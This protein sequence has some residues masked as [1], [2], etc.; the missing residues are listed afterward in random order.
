MTL[1][2]L[3]MR[4]NTVLCAI[5][6]LGFVACGGGSVDAMPTELETSIPSPPTVITSTTSPT[7]AITSTSMPIP[8]QSPT[9][10]PSP[11]FEPCT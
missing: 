11:T 3:A 5:A 10:I 4:F 8:T 2:Q 7:S 9:S 6:L 1:V